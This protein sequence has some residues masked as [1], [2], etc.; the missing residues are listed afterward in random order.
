[1]YI[2]ASDGKWWKST[3]QTEVKKMKANANRTDL[4]EPGSEAAKSSKIAY[5]KVATEKCSSMTCLKYQVTS[6]GQGDDTLFI[7][8]DTTDYQLRRTTNQTGD[9]S[10]D[11]LYSYGNV[12]I[13]P[14]SN[15]QT[16]KDG[17]TIEPGD[18]EP[19]NIVG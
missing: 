10:Y 6:A 8:I 2:R 17:Q 19:T 16:L 12:G 7:W 9:V 15:F 11:A 18:S 4:P 1:V 14:P 13:S 5:K 3:D